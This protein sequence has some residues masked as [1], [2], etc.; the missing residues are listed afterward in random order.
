MP[1]FRTSPLLGLTLSGLSLLGPL[2][3]AQ[4]PEPT[5]SPRIHFVRDDAIWSC[6]PDGGDAREELARVAHGFGPFAVLGNETDPA[7]WSFGLPT[8]WVWQIAWWV[9]GVVMMYLLAF[10]LEMSTVP[11]PEVRALVESD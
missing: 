8:L 5:P 3:S 11:R 6:A 4:P 2:A 10:K 9:V 7:A 1:T